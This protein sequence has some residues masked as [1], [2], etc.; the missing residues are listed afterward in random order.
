MNLVWSNINVCSEVLDQIIASLVDKT[1]DEL[2]LIAAHTSDLTTYTDDTIDF[3]YIE[4][5]NLGDHA[6]HSI[7]GTLQVA[8]AIAVGHTQC[9]IG[10]VAL[11]DLDM[12]D[13]N[14]KKWEFEAQERWFLAKKGKFLS[15]AK[16][17]IS[18]RDGTI[19][20]VVIVDVSALVVVDTGIAFV[21]KQVSPLVACV[22][23]KLHIS[24]V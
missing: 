16:S 2:S 8:T 4:A 11:K 22:D 3:G 24:L 6:K 7:L 17:Y 12:S 18:D 13:L 1:S 21:V 9:V 10:R 23:Q 14:I 15:Q 19:V 20:R 5:V